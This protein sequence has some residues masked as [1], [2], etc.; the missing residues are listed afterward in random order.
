MNVMASA[1]KS[2]ILGGLLAGLTYFCMGA[3]VSVFLK[4]ARHTASLAIGIFFITSVVG[5]LPEALGMLDFL[6]WIS[7]VEY[8]LPREIVK[9]GIDAV[10]VLICLIVMAVCVAASYLV[11]RKKDFA[12]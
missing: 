11:Y 5:A 9:N 3:L 10:H 1:M 8:F 2:V 12:V 6:R 4:K 7:P